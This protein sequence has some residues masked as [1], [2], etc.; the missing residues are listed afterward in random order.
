MAKQ[1]YDDVASIHVG[2]DILRSIGL[3]EKGGAKH[4]GDITIGHLK[5]GEKER[6]R[7]RRETERQRERKRE[8]ERNRHDT[9]VT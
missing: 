7:K 3:E 1:L 9:V 2:E 5:G 6:E 8:R 4:N